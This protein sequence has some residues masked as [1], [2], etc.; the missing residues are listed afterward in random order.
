MHVWGIIN[1]VF[2]DCVVTLTAQIRFRSVGCMFV[3]GYRYSGDL[4]GTIK[5]QAASY[6]VY[7]VDGMP[8][9]RGQAEL[10]PG[11]IES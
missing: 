6:R 8:L 3:E 2:T 5:V 7:R 1:V 4:G 11:G 10:P 9:K